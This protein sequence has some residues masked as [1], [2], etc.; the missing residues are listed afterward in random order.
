MP[1]STKHPPLEPNDRRREVARILARGVIR[2]RKRAQ[3]GHF[4]HTEAPQN[5]S[6]TGLAQCG[7]TSLS[8]SD[9]TRG[10]RLRDDGDEA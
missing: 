9:G 10:L 5:P 7:E 4:A 8:L 6:G 2:W 3:V 1:S